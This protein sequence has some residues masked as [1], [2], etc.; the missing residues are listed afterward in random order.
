MKSISTIAASMML[1]GASAVYADPANEQAAQAPVKM[2]DAQ[3]DQ[4]AAGQQIWDG[5]SLIG[6]NVQVDRTNVQL[7]VPVNAQVA[8]QVLTRD[9]NIEQQQ[10]PGRIL[11]SPNF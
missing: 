2:T 5:D 8:A 1:F 10:R 4:I 3:L 6:V 9:S 11:Q 7:A